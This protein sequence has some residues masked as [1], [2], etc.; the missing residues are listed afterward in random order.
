MGMGLGLNP[1][2]DSRESIESGTSDAGSIPAL[3]TSEE[4]VREKTVEAAMNLLLKATYDITANRKR[5]L[6][7]GFDNRKI[8]RKRSL[9]MNSIHAR[10]YS[11]KSGKCLRSKSLDRMNNGPVQLGPLSFSLKDKD[12]AENAS[13]STEPMASE[14]GDH[15]E[16]D[17]SKK[18]SKNTSGLKWR[19]K[20]LSRITSILPWR[21]KV[22]K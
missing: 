3:F 1:S 9:S 6:D 17:N 18:Q 2:I 7:T 21:R 14:N 22:I 4:I 16:D 10:N 13:V 5:K 20:R 11:D 12:C 8:P 19:R 15:F